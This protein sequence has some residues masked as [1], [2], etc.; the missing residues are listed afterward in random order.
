MNDWTKNSIYFEVEGS[1]NRYYM[2]DVGQS[3]EEGPGNRKKKD[4]TEKLH[5]TMYLGK[6]PLG[7]KSCPK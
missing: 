1:A 6:L 7:Y 2:K 4:L 5:I 3:L